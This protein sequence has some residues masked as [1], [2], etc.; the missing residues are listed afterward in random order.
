MRAC[1]LLAL[2]F[3]SLCRAQASESLLVMTTPWPPFRIADGQGALYG[4]DIDVLDEL[5][6]RTGLRFELQQ[7]PWARGLTALQHGRADLMI[8]LA[9]TPE[10]ERYIHYLPMPYYTCAPRFYAAPALAADLRGYED[11]RSL[12]IGYVLQSAYFA[13]FDNDRSLSK[14]G[15][16]SERQLLHMLVRGRI[17]VL[18]GTD[19]QVDYALLAPEFAGRIVKA[20]YRPP[21]RTDLYIGFSR[22][23][24]AHAEQLA[25]ALE[26][27]LEDGW[28]AGMAQR[29][30]VVNSPLQ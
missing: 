13:Q 1:A 10:R 24:L 25:E 21:M 7:A 30:Q 23:R 22:L 18:V 3:F 8:G 19:C 11:L 26:A 17:D 9:R 27:M 16:T 20:A 29:Y 6:R 12:K 4:L 28:I 15:V 14:V 2:M 5:S